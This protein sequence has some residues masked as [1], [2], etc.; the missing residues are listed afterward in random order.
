[1]PFYWAGFQQTTR[2]T[3]VLEDLTD[4]RQIWNGMRSKLHADIRKAVRAQLKIREID[5]LELFYRLNK[6]SFERQAVE[7]PY[8]FDL[9]ARID[10]A[11][12]TNAGRRMLLAEDSAGRIHA[13]DYL[14]YD[15]RCAISLLRG[16]DG[17]LRSSGASCLLQWEMIQFAST[18]SRRFDFEG[19]MME[20]LERHIRSFGARQVPYFTIFGQR[21]EADCSNDPSRAR[22]FLGRA[23]R[24]A[25]QLIDPV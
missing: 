2:Y 21:R 14:V 19:S 4:T 8:N 20:T 10:K 18:V 6:K 11:C 3:Y 17:E 12:G 23:L 5:D 25:A 22:R 7:I 16:A 13:A 15:S 1:L 9:V 24:K